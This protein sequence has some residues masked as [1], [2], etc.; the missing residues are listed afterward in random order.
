MQVGSMF[1][2]VSHWVHQLLFVLKTAHVEQLR[3][4]VDTLETERTAYRKCE[5][6]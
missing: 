3:H 6:M 4:D 1:N 5:L 2:K